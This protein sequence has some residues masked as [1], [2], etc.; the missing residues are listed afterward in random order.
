M[1]FTLGV[2]GRDS[3]QQ[4]KQ[5]FYEDFSMVDVTT[6]ANNVYA[7]RAA[8]IILLGCKRYML[9]ECCNHNV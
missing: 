3:A 6:A 1:K 2:R 8:Q 7:V 4:L 5:E 9:T